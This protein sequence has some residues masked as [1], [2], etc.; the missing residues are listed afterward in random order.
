MTRSWKLHLVALAALAA[1]GL[2]RSQASP[3]QG[4]VV[5][6]WGTFTT[7]Q[8][9]HGAAIGG[10][11]TDDEPVPDFVHNINGEVT[12]QLSQL[13]G[14]M[15]KA[16]P[17]CHPDVYT[18]LETPVIY[19]Y[20][21]PGGV[22]PIDVQVT[23]KGG[24]LTQYYP[25]ALASG[26]D[27][28]GDGELRFGR[29]NDQTLGNLAWQRLTVGGQAAGPATTDKV[30]LAPR[31]VQAASVTTPKGEK[32]RYIFYRGVSRNNPPLRVVRHGDDLS[33]QSQWDASIPSPGKP[34]GPVWLVDVR[35]DGQLAFRT[36]GSLDL[37][38]GVDK[39]LSSVSSN[40]TDADY[41]K[42]NLD[43]I[44]KEMH[45]A[46]E[47]DG[48]FA[49]EATALLNTWRASYFGRP[50]LRLFFMTPRQWTE[51]Y[52]PMKISEPADITRVMIGRIEIVTPSQRAA[53]AKIAAGPA[54]SAQ[55]AHQALQ[56][57]GARAVDAYRED[58]Y[59]QMSGPNSPLAAMGITI[60]ADYRAYLELGRFRNALVN[61]EQ[62]RRPTEA[63][64]NFI[65]NYQLA[66]HDFR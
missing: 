13:P 19:F 22:G 23:F 49:D 54:S 60:P 63:L 16:I 44:A 35:N 6:E 51:H 26:P 64:G 39:D 9:E 62:H 29:L 17:R 41:A 3:V 40:F 1:V 21:P 50:G 18:R 45:A 59:R 42:D 66:L 37:S 61:D 14:V 8:D 25:D 33:V 46:L 56:K 57:L 11:N 10:I 58:W 27:V 38:R 48:L 4:L 28:N 55:W 47:R 52:L 12:P 5:H 32:E 65:Q 30:W 24:W 36:I 20:P 15:F 7:L 31:N 43:R 2:G 53:L 34:L